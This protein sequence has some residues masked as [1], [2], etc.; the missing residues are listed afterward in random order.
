MDN[1]INKSREIIGHVQVRDSTGNG[2]RVVYVTRDPVTEER[3][4]EIRSRRHIREGF[5]RLPIKY[6][7]LIM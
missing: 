4:R 6:I 7:H 1:S 5:E 2:F 3:Y